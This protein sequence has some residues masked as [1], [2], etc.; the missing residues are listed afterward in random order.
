MKGSMRCTFLVLVLLSGIALQLSRGLNATDKV[1]Q[2]SKDKDQDSTLDL[3]ALASEIAALWEGK[4]CYA[5]PT[6]KNGED[7]ISLACNAEYSAAERN[8]FLDFVFKK[9]FVFRRESYTVS[10]TTGHY[11]YRLEWRD[12]QRRRN[13][14]VRMHIISQGVLWGARRP[15]SQVAIYVDNL[16]TADELTAWQTLG[17]P[18]AFGLK[19]DENAKELAQQIE[20]YKQEAW[21]ALDPKLSSLTEED[22]DISL[23]EV[24]EQDLLA[25]YFKDAL[26]QTGDVW[27]ITIRALNPITTNVATV[28]ALFSAI[29]AEGKSYVLLPV[30]RHPALDTTA[31][32]MGMNAQRVSHDLTAM[33]ARSPAR[34]WN[35]IRNQAKKGRMIVRF[36][37]RAKR[38]AL[39]LSRTIRR[40]GSI[41]FRPLSTFFG[42][43][44]TVPQEK[45]SEN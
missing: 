32:V 7:V 10:G 8:K 9:G 40:D 31:H 4:Q 44:E 29:K 6:A 43:T 30:N 34:V 2:G 26:E 13:L 23:R 12:G 3:A 5:E 45:S 35:F 33:C 1:G 37:A 39:T 22:S 18:I 28:R 20:Q 42:Y 15:P 21:L 16:A 24:L 17:I 25:N 14:Y 38:C 19:P 41:D 36:S 27:G 11:W